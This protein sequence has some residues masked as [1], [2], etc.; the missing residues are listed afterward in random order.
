MGRG[1][2]LARLIAGTCSVGRHRPRC[3]LSSARH[4]GGLVRVIPAREAARR[5]PAE[6]LAAESVTG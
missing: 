6:I 5:S 1:T 3:C 4:A 2:L